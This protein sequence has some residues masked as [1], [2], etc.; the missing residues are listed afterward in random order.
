M[1]QTKVWDKTVLILTTDH[2]LRNKN[3]DP[4]VP[5]IVKFP[6]QTYPVLYEKKFNAIVVYKFFKSLLMKKQNGPEDL[7]QI[8]EEEQNVSK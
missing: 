3:Q 5:F 7:I 4:R 6:G 1:E 8:I 2:S